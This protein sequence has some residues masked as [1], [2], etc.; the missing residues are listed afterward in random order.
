[1]VCWP[2]TMV[3][4]RSVVKCVCADVTRLVF[5]FVTGIGA[6]TVLVAT[7]GAMTGV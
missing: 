1:M 3:V 4:G 6:T 2:C 7:L 5:A